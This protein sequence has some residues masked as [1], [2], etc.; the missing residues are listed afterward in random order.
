MKKAEPQAAD[1]PNKANIARMI[2]LLQDGKDI[3]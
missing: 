3:N 1:Q 2:P